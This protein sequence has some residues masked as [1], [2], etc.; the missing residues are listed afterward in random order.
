VSRIHEALR[1]SERE[2]R[3]SEA[4]AESAKPVPVAQVAVA[5]QPA[6]LAGAQSADIRVSPAAHLVAL[7]D[8]MSLGAEKFRVLATRIENLRKN[9]DL[10]SLQVTSGASNE[11]KSLV[12]ANLAF[13]LARRSNSKV[14]L[15]EGDLHKPALTSMFGL[16]D[17][18]G[19]GQW[20]SKPDAEITQFM[21]QLNGLP[22]WLLA[23]GKA[24][25]QPS[26]IL[27]SGRFGKAFAQLVRYFDWIVVDS[28]PLLPMADVNL[29]SRW[30]NGTLLV[31]REGVAPISTL[32][33]GLAG[34]DNAKL[35]GVV[36]NEASEFDQANYYNRRYP[37]QTVEVEEQLSEGKP[38]VVA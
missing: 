5:T 16:D 8:P 33:K 31:V 18:K 7:T 10:T 26:D 2:N 14:L 19:L 3:Q 6:G 34:L 29:W 21:Y 38:E 11:G 25:D 28:T 36:L 23:A 22:L 35:L 17:A 4:A 1:K 30:V 13:T 9:G 20:W 24:F 27:Q 37:P 12:S 32:R 15:I